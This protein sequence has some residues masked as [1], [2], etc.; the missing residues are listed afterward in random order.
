M[1]FTF[2]RDKYYAGQLI[3]AKLSLTLSQI[4]TAVNR[5]SITFEGTES[6]QFP[7]ESVRRD[8]LDGEETVSS[9][10][11]TEKHCIFRYRLANI[12]GNEG[13]WMKGS[14]VIP[15]CLQTPTTAPPSLSLRDGAR[16]AHIRYTIRAV[17]HRHGFLSA[18]MV[19]HAEIRI[20]G[21]QT[22]AALPVTP[23]IHQ[24]DFTLRFFCCIPRGHVRLLA[25]LPSVTT[26]SVPVEATI[27][28]RT[29]KIDI[30]GLQLSHY[31]MVNLMA[32]RHFERFKLKDDS[33]IKGPPIERGELVQRSMSLELNTNNI[34][35][36]FK[37]RLVEIEHWIRVRLNV[38]FYYLTPEMSLIVNKI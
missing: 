13:W 30:E 10:I 33:T 34:P 21:P 1:Q 35:N 22:D 31:T 2:D 26:G 29:G 4:S 7:T 18:K 36:T 9:Q 24:E 6:V 12:L 37:S 16:E 5:L 23:A 28:N 8:G 20:L 11:I 17:L 38:P 27:D 19:G 15:I 3:Y 14:Y 25:S 32:Q